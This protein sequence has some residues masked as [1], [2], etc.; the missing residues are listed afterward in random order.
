MRKANV[1]YC[2]E[3]SKYIYSSEAKATRALNRYEDIKRV[4]FCEYCKGFHTTSMSENAAI[5]EGIIK[6]KPSL[7][8][9]KKD[10]K[11]KIKEL[12]SKLNRLNG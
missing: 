4:Y 7:K 10:I 8:I 6:E 3:T 2:K 12:E 5:M 11:L 1:E 9:S